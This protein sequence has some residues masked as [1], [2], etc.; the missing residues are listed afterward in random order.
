MDRKSTTITGMDI[1]KDKTYSGN[2]RKTIE[3]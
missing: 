1:N 2:P 3:D